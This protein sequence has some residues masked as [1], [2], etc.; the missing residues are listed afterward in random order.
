M[1][2]PIKL[3]HL[4]LLLALLISGP[5][6]LAQEKE[7]ELAKKQDVLEEQKAKQEEKMLKEQK[8]MQEEQKA[9][10]AEK[11]HKAQK[12]MQE[13]ELQ[14][15]KRM[16]EQQQKMQQLEYEYQKQKKQHE[17][18]RLSRESSRGVRAETRTS[19]IRSEGDYMIA[20]PF[21]QSNQSQLTL[22]NNFDGGSD[23]SKG[24]FEV[25]EDSRH[26]KCMISGKVKSGDIYISVKYPDGK[27]FKELKINS[28]AEVNF[29][30]SRTM[31]DGEKDRYI[32]SWS[33]E[34]KA[35]KAEGIYML[36]IMTY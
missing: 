9:M 30:Q 10:Q 23:T 5:F 31:K 3:K 8:E 12:E 18:E 4:I 24:K 6:L 33:Y 28:A 14:A 29:T 19:G 20:A 11:M 25:G 15:K 36:Q 7:E 16:L 26:F 13:M 17:L 32:G 2:T 22:R 21:V 34:V 27:V 1:K 35:N